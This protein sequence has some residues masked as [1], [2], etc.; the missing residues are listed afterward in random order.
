VKGI[1]GADL[2]A[3]EFFRLTNPFRARTG[4]SMTPGELGCVLSHAK[5]LKMA[6]ESNHGASLILED[7]F[8]ASDSALEW[9]A[10]VQQH[11]T[12]GTLMHL[13]GQEHM[14]RFYRMVRGQPLPTL[15]CVASVYTD[16]FP[17][18]MCTVAYMVNGDTAKSLSDLMTKEPYLADDFSNALRHGAINRIWFRWVIS[19][20]VEQTD[21]TIASDRLLLNATTK[22]HWSYRTRMNWARL[23][24]SLTTP[25]SR[26]LRRQQPAN[27]LL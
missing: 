23:W 5:A 7:D 15:P 4:R 19:H 9:I 2:S 25:P 13:G 22:R 12:S 18:L 8:I 16:D 27:R 20:P 10:Q 17:F 24:R 21:S 3:G 6:A 11:V 26:F 1:K 14:S